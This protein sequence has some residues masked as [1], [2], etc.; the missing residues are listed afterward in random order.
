M[1]RPD[2]SRRGLA[3]I[4]VPTQR[5]QATSPCNRRTLSHQAASRLSTR[6]SPYDRPDYP[7][8]LVNVAASNRS[9]GVER[10]RCLATV[11]WSWV[12]PTVGVHRN[13]TLQPHEA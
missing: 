3:A 4:R 2:G 1:E 10:A 6:A 5:S 11:G 12:G 13:R 9:T 7:I 8:Y